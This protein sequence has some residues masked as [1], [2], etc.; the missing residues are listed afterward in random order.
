MLSFAQ[1]AQVC[2]LIYKRK[3][4]FCESRSGRF[5]NDVVLRWKRNK[6]W[7]DN[8]TNVMHVFMRIISRYSVCV[9]RFTRVFPSNQA[10]IIFFQMQLKCMRLI[11]Y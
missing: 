8:G 7:S 1:L 6:L 3:E 11:M 5:V 2:N 10:I 4:F 9:L